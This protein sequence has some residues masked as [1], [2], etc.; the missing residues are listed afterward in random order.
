MD[1]SSIEHV[2]TAIRSAKLDDNSTSRASQSFCRS[3]SHLLYRVLLAAASGD[4]ATVAA[5]AA[6]PTFRGLL[7]KALR[8]RNA[9]EEKLQPRRLK[10][11]IQW[12]HDSDSLVDEAIL[13]RVRAGVWVGPKS[14]AEVLA[15]INASW[16]QVQ[17]RYRY[18]VKTGVIRQS[19]MTRR[20]VIC[21]QASTV[22]QNSEDM[23]DGK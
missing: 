13:R 22:E 10:K 1:G 19:G 20:M 3:E 7:K 2:V 9:C 15:E 18:L 8:C 11:R 21:E 16:K 12:N 5:C 4:T 14:T 23:A 6:D 17:T